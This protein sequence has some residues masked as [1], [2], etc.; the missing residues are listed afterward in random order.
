MRIERFKAILTPVLVVTSLLVSMLAWTCE[1]EAQSA[2]DTV[3][4]GESGAYNLDLTGDPPR[5]WYERG[6][7]PPFMAASRCGDGAVVA[8][9]TVCSC[10]NGRWNDDSNPYPHLDVLF[11]ATFQWMVPDASNVLWYEGYDVYNDTNR[12]SDMITALQ[13][14]GYSVAG[15]DTMPITSDLLSSYDILVIPQFELGASGTGGDPSLFPDADVEVI[16]SFVEGGGGLLIM[17]GADFGGYNYYKVHNK[18]LEALNFGLGFQDDQIYDNENP[19]NQPYELLAEVDDGTEIE[20]AYEA[21]TGGTTVGLYAVCSLA[22][23]GPSVE[24]QVIPEYQMGDLGTTLEYT[25]VVTNLESPT[26]E[27]LTCT[28]TV[29]DSASWNPTLKNNTV[30]VPVGENRVTTLSVT[31]PENAEHCTKDNIQVTATSSEAGVSDS[32]NGVAHAVTAAVS[33]VEVSISPSEDNGPPGTV[34]SYTVTVMNMGTAD[35]NYNLMASDNAD[36]SLSISPSILTLAAGASDTATLSVVIPIAAEN[37]TRD[38]ITVTATSIE[39][40]EVSDS[41]SCVAHAFG[42]APVREVEVSISPTSKSGTPGENLVYYI[43]VRNLSESGDD[44]H[45]EVTNTKGWDSNLS[46][47]SFWLNKAGR[48]WGRGILLSIKV[49]DSAA[50]GDLSTITVTVSGTGYENQVTCTATVERAGLPWISIAGII[51]AIIMIIGALMII[52]S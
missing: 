29:E 10:R 52:R 32:D 34:L 38:N 44:F 15:D 37:C 4:R 24:V 26:A 1:V 36:W 19:W 25:I 33:G 49:P 41:A 11:D 51:V 16:E 13:D 9:S 3:M 43:E 45:L 6:D 27:D 7:L 50:E 46:V 30:T 12:C 20:T 14:L 2:E 42:V 48:S 35:D 31:I 5:V 17:D 22:L 8:A 28:L 47:T 39:N 21:A 23:I 18:I 40:S